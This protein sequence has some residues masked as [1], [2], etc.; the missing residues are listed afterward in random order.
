M[1]QPLR[2]CCVKCVIHHE[3]DVHEEQH[4]TYMWREQAMI[5]W[6]WHVNWTLLFLVATVR[7]FA[8]V[9][10]GISDRNNS[11]VW[12]ERGK[13]D[14]KTNSKC[15]YMEL[16]NAV[17][18][19]QMLLYTNSKCCYM[20]HTCLSLQRKFR[21]GWTI[22]I[23]DESNVLWSRTEWQPYNCLNE[24]EFAYNKFRYNDAP[25]LAPTWYYIR[26]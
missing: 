10:L 24:V 23:S 1:L 18:E 5:E 12:S 16:Q 8:H 4:H 14:K 6:S 3:R 26:V 20:A 13:S 21:K 9:P 17:I 11:A 2:W 15:C 22:P 19:Q 7:S 25:S